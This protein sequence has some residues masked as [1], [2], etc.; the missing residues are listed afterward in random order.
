VEL[1]PFELNPLIV[2]YAVGGLTVVALA[3]ALVIFRLSKALK[4]VTRFGERLVHLTSAM[5]LLTDTTE[6]GLTNVGLALE[7]SAPPRAARS[8]RG[9]TAK[10]I[11]AAARTGRAIEEIAADESLSQSEVR[12]HVQMKSQALDEG[13]VDASLRG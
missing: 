4:A 1:N 12:L 3:E 10:R 7:R 2:V 13:A 11:A 9:A 6:A 5:E 8:T